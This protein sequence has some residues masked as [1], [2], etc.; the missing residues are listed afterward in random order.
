[1]RIFYENYTENNNA[2]VGKPQAA[3]RE[4]GKVN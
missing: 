3:G 2:I 1:M 4:V